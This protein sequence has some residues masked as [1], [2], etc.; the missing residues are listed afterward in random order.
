ML[1]WLADRG[2]DLL[3]VLSHV[4][5]EHER[6]VSGRAVV[7]LPGPPI[8][9]DLLGEPRTLEDTHDLAVEMDGAGQGKD[10]ALAIVD[11]DREPGLPEQVG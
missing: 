3:Q 5:V 6:D 1:Q 10:L 7:R 9:R 11:L 2:T 8:D 4:G